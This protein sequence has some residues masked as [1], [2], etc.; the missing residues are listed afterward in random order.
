MRHPPPPLWPTVYYG[1][2]LLGPIFPILTVVRRHAAAAAARAV[3]VVRGATG[4]QPDPG[5]QWR[6]QW[7]AARS[8][9]PGARAPHKGVPVAAAV[10]RVGLYPIATFQYSST[11]LYHV[12]CHTQYLC[13]ESGSRTLH[14]NRAAHLRLRGPPR[15]AQPRAH[16]H[17][18]PLPATRTGVLRVDESGGGP[19]GGRPSSE[20]A[21]ACAAA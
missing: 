17:S 12:A 19:N 10:S 2:W 18:S 9:D 6:T 13:F 7:Q 21:C 20:P 1:K 14:P 5:A 4:G 15:P 3:A 16:G 11:T 8:P